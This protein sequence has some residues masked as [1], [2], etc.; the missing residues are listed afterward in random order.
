MTLAFTPSQTVGP[1]YAIGMCR[2]T[3]HELAPGGMKIAGRLLDGAGAPIPDGVIELWS[4][5]AGAWG[6]CGTQPAGEFMFVAEKPPAAPGEAPRFDVLVFARGLLR[7]QVTRLYFP[8]EE[9][10]NAGDPVLSALSPDDRATLVAA[11]DG[12]GLRFDIRMQGESQTVFF[13]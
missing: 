5:T 9:A 6:R 13:A 7:H 1:Y 12:D 4:A 3:E 11:A 10:A 2:R 8:D